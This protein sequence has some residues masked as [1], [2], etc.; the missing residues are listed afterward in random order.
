MVYSF[1]WQGFF[2]RLCI[3]CTTELRFNLVPLWFH[4]QYWYE[5]W[6]KY[7]NICAHLHLRW[8][9]PCHSTLTRM[10]WKDFSWYT[11]WSSSYDCIKDSSLLQVRKKEIWWLSVMTLFGEGVKWPPLVTSRPLGIGKWYLEGI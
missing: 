9:L 5:K 7:C 1:T 2:Y 3:S 11:D 6:L 4:I 8:H 10:G